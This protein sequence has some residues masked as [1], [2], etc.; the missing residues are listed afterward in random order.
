MEGT[1]VA[2]DGV[3]CLTKC[4]EATLAPDFLSYETL[5]LLMLV[6]NLDFMSSIPTDRIPCQPASS[7]KTGRLA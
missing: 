3:D 4:S 6:L 2:A 5:R 1:Q 7:I